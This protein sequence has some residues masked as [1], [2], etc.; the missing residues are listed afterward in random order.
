MRDIACAIAIPPSDGFAH[1]GTLGLPYRNCIDIISDLS[2]FCYLRLSISI[3]SYAVHIAQL[4]RLTNV[5]QTANRTW[6]T[7]MS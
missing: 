6:T 2:I 3:G 7:W 1:V 4:T 5:I